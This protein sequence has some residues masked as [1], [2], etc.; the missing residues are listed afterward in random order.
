MSIRRGRF[1]P[2]LFWLAL[3]VLP[4]GVTAL[5]AAVDPAPHAP[6]GSTFGAPVDAS[7]ETS[8]PGQDSN[9]VLV[10]FKPGV[11]PTDW[12]SIAAAADAT[13]GEPI[14]ATDYVLVKTKPGR[15]GKTLQALERDSRVADAELNYVRRALTIPSDPEY[16]RQRHYFERLRLPEA[17]DVANAVADVRVAVVDTGVDAG[18]PDL[19]GRVLQGHDFVNDDSDAYD[20]QWHGTWVAAIIAANTNDGVG[21]AGVSPS[22]RILPVKVLDSYGNGT[23]ANIAAGITWAADHGADVINLSLAASQESAVIRQAVEYALDH[24]V[25]V[26]AAAGNGGSETPQYPA[27]YSGVVAVAATDAHGELASFSN[28]GPWIDIA[29]PGVNITSARSRSSYEVMSGTS[30]AAP[31]VSG[32]A[33]LVHALHPSATASQIVSQLLESAQDAGPIGVDHDFGHGIL[34]AFAAV[35]ASN[36]VPA[37]P[38]APTPPTLPQPPPAAPD[39][40]PATP[41][42]APGTPTIVPAT[43]VTKESRRPTSAV[44]TIRG[45]RVWVSMRG[46]ARISLVCSRPPSCR[47]RITLRRRANVL[48]SASFLIRPGHAE[49]ITVQL[50]PSARRLLTS[51]RLRI[52]RAVATS[53]TGR[54]TA[55]RL[56]HLE[57]A[58]KP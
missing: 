30:Y 15:V 45:T 6:V 37:L 22:A 25:V 14:R 11:A 1:W 54:V 43:E 38:S 31:F 10:R 46:T 47:G 39:V 18:Q 27:A 17:W 28:H 3:G 49:P 21:I 23:D 44:L 13:V 26:V 41:S 5:N 57:V 24:D 16:S 2:R 50:R 33:T 56:V 40:A 35:T 36:G 8:K 48:G 19:A 58:R 34:D 4:I 12:K 52:S 20:D 51:E 7:P 55:S 32:V 9:T 53:T 29:A 42:P